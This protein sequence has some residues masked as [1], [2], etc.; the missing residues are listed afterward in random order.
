MLLTNGI[1]CTS[2]Y[3][4][5]GHFDGLVCVTEVYLDVS[6]LAQERVEGEHT[7]TLR[8]WLAHCQKIMLLNPAFGI[9]IPA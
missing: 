4:G 9:S 3:F 8:V 2:S 7:A 1:G 6:F 5:R